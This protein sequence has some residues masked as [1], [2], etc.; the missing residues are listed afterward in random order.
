MHRSLLCFL[1]V[2]LTFAMPA[3][4]AADSVGPAR[5]IDGNTVEVRGARLLLASMDAPQPGQICTRFDARYDCGKE[6]STELGRIIAGRPLRCMPSGKDQAQRPLMRCWAG[7]ID[8]GRE[9]VRRGWAVAYNGYAY[10]S[11]ES[12]AREARRGIWDGEF[13]R[14]ADWRRERK[15]SR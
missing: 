8:V 5:V 15:R 7:D 11:D 12:E 10:T 13:Q 6:A 4:Q 1:I 3:A 9:L 14:P 2:G